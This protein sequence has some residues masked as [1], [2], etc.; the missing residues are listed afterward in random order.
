[1]TTTWSFDL[2]YPRPPKG[3]SAND[4]CHW[5]TENDNIQMIR[6]ETMLRTRA[7]K[8]PGLDS[9]RVDVEWVVADRRNRDTDNLAPLLKAIYDGIGSNRGTSARIVDDDDPA[10]MQKPSAT[11]RFQAGA[12]PHF[13]V[14]ITDIGDDVVPLQKQGQN[15]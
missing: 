1:M 2:N 3:L 9:I 15:K 12:E 4:R 11:I 5:R 8:V 7:A 10:H 6:K 14:T 13:T